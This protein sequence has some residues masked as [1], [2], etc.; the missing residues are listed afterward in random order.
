MKQFLKSF[1]DQR[2]V[3]RAICLYRLQTTDAVTRTARALGGLKVKGQQTTECAHTVQ[4]SRLW[5][6]VVGREHQGQL[7]AGCGCAGLESVCGAVRT[8]LLLVLRDQPCVRVRGLHRQTAAAT[9]CGGVEGPPGHGSS[10][11]HG[12]LVICD[13]DPRTLYLVD[14]VQGEKLTLTVAR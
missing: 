3:T 13:R 12:Q 1:K 7:V 4:V 8:V 14:V 9:P 11:A 6:E 10:T 2:I 5:S